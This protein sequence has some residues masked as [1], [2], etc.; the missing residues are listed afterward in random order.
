MNTRRQFLAGAAS[1]AFTS[2]LFGA[3]AEKTTVIGASVPNRREI[4]RQLRYLYCQDPR[5]SRG[6]N[7]IV[8]QT[9]GKC[10]DPVVKLVAFNY[11]LLGDAFVFNNKAGSPWVIE[12]DFLE[13]IG[14]S[15]QLI[16]T[17]EFK[18]IV[19]TKTPHGVYEKIPTYVR[20]FVLQGKNIPLDKDRLIRFKSCNSH[21]DGWSKE[22]ALLV[23]P[24]RYKYARSPLNHTGCSTDEL[25]GENFEPS[26]SP[27]NYKYVCNRISEAKSGYKANVFSVKI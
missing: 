19:L 25:F 14:D 6:I 18:Q 4:N 12:S 1:I 9:V 17:K 24:F 10:S 13:F 5:F 8:A 3:V 7:E 27:D 23:S 21:F 15:P 16:P 2:K 26:M 20:K 11:H 22:S